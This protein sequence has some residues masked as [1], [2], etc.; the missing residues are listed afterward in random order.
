MWVLALLALGG[1]VAVAQI[2]WTP[3]AAPLSP[4]QSWTSLAAGAALV[5]VLVAASTFDW[6]RRGWWP[7]VAAAMG[8]VAYGGLDLQHH[9]LTPDD[10]GN[11]LR[12]TNHGVLQV[13]GSRGQLNHKGLPDLA[14]W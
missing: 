2:S 7:L 6:M 3:P 1:S 5:L 14:L 10:P 8:L 11:R 12:G 9:R 4:A 13:K